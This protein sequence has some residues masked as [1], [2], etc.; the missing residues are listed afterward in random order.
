MLLDGLVAPLLLALFGRQLRGSVLQKEA[1]Q[2]N[3]NKRESGDD[4][5]HSQNIHFAF[6]QKGILAVFG[7][8]GVLCCHLRPRS[9]TIRPD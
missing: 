2:S 4:E 6:S 1:C 9:L 3:T 5:P 8:A 7:A